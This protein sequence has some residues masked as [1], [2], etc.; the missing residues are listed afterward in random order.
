M[1]LLDIQLITLEPGG[2]APVATPCVDLWP[3][4]G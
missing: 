3:V 4:A 1:E 2:T